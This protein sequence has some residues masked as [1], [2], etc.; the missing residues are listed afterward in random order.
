MVEWVSYFG[1]GHTPDIGWAGW[2]A[3]WLNFLLE[4]YF[5]VCQE[6]SR[7]F[8]DRMAV[9]SVNHVRK[10]P[11]HFLTESTA[12][13]QPVMNSILLDVAVDSVRKKSGN[14]LT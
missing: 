12:G 10:F 3:G 4:L 9:R 6:H 11:G 5:Q 2:Q 13:P 7:H 14:S 1:V 8:P